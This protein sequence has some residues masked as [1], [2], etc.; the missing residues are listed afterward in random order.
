[1][2]SPIKSALIDNCVFDNGVLMEIA[3]TEKKIPWG[4]Q[5]VSVPLTGMKR[6]PARSK[7]EEWL[8]SQINSL[9]TLARIAMEGGIELCSYNEIGFE[10]WNRKGGLFGNSAIN[11]FQNVTFRKIPPAVERSKFRQTIDLKKYLS[12]DEIISFC[13]FLLTPDIKDIV[14]HPEIRGMLTDFE[15]EN[16]RGISRFETLCD[17]LAESQYPDAFHLWTA[18]TNKVDFFLTTDGK[19]IRVMTETKRI[20]LPCKPICP[21]DLLEELGVTDLDPTPFDRDQFYTV[22]GT[23]E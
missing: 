23:P 5:E 12:R 3:V 15:V 7:D 14:D 18:E 17:G 4:N 1:M 8:Q 13:K 11:V 21:T 16:L 6:R 22:F 10:S 19:F 2:N 20:N 9:P